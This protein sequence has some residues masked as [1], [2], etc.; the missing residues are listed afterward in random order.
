M[1]TVA[2]SKHASKPK[3]EADDLVSQFWES[4]EDLRA[5]RVKRVR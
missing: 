3:A 2:I 4:L 5:G 1:K